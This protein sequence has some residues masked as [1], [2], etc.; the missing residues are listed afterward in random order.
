MRNLL[1][2]KGM[3]GAEGGNRTHD[4]SITNRLLYR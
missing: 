3:F 4:L 2:I 1:Q